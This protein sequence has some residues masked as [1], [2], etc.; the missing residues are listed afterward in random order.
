GSAPGEG[1]SRAARHTA[2]QPVT[3]TATVALMPANSRDVLYRPASPPDGTVLYGGFW[4]ARWDRVH[5]RPMCVDLSGRGY[6][7]ASVE[8]RRLGTGGGWPATFED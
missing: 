1:S 3:W 6:P 7:V 8:Y 5:T 2:K 4:S